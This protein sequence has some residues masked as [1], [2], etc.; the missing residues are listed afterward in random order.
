MTYLGRFLIKSA[1]FTI[2][3]LARPLLASESP[4]QKLIDAIESEDIPAC[5][6]AFKNGASL[7]NPLQDGDNALSLAI[8]GQKLKVLAW[9]LYETHVVEMPSQPTMS[10]ES[11]TEHPPKLKRSKSHSFNLACYLRKDNSFSS[12]SSQSE[13]PKSNPTSILAQPITH[14]THGR[15][16]LFTPLSGGN[17]YFHLA[18]QFGGITMLEFIFRAI[19]E[20]YREVYLNQ[21]NEAGQ[22]PLHLAVGL[23]NIV[24]LLRHNANPNIGTPSAF[25]VVQSLDVPSLIDV[26]DQYSMFPLE[27]NANPN[28]QIFI[29]SNESKK[30]EEEELISSGEKKEKS[31]EEKKKKKK[32]N[33]DL[34][35]YPLRTESS[36]F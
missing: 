10:S 33:V 7:K 24:W 20:E 28:S 8:K 36:F 18:V 27:S 34:V 11:S 22:T 4:N 26:Y 35:N 14:T 6:D 23:Q 32:P 5:R 17:N 1:F 31:K 29:T 30:T 19:I 9:I 3:F 25:H 21:M 12:D 13:S 15:Y 2:L 16:I